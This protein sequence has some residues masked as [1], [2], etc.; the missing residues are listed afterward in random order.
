MGRTAIDPLQKS[1]YLGPRQSPGQ[2][3]FPINPRCFQLQVKGAGDLPLGVLEAEK[4]AQTDDQL[5][6]AGA[7]TDFGAQTHKRL[8]LMER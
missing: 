3:L 2:L 6:E 8:N 4:A 5:L 1:L 7:F